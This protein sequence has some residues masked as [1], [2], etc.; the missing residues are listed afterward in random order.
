M[1]RS[2]VAMSLEVFCLCVQLVYRHYKDKLYEFMVL[3][4]PVLQIDQMK[5][6][7]SEFS[8]LYFRIWMKLILRMLSDLGDRVDHDSKGNLGKE[9]SVMFDI[10]NTFLRFIPNSDPQ[11]PLCYSVVLRVCE[12]Q[13]IENALHAKYLWELLFSTQY[14]VECFPVTLLSIAEGLHYCLGDIVDEADLPAP[15]RMFASICSSTA[16]MILKLFLS[17][18]DKVMD[19]MKCAT[20]DLRYLLVYND[21]TVKPSRILFYEFKFY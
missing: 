8:F 19:D 17:H 13:S 18:L 21:R 2:L 20:S 16:P 11:I 3:L 12:E 15:K 14:I 1:V 6:D 10:A 9:V 4:A 7:V 5:T